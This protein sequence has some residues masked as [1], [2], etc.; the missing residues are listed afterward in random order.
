MTPG[1]IAG[2]IH[3]G[4][5]VEEHVL[6]DGVPKKGITFRSVA[7]YCGWSPRT[8]DLILGQAR[9]ESEDVDLLWSDGNDDE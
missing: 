7:D 5:L 1:A 2:A 4:R 6:I 8:V 3:R 9:I